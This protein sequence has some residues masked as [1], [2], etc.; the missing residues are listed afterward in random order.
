MS[1][2][3]EKSAALLNTSKENRSHISYLGLYF[4]NFLDVKSARTEAGIYHMFTPLI[5]IGLRFINTFIFFK[6]NL[7]K[8]SY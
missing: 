2:I 7:A 4:T 8:A 6:K 5:H 1:E 3:K